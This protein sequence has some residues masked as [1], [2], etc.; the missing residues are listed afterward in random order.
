MA[1]VP[2][3]LATEEVPSPS[4]EKALW[5]VAQPPAA[6]VW[7]Q[8]S[9]PIRSRRP[10]H[11]WERFQ[12]IAEATGRPSKSPE[13]VSTARGAA[14]G[15]LP[16]LNQPGRAVFDHFCRGQPRL[17]HARFAE[18]CSPGPTEARYQGPDP[19]RG[20]R[21]PCQWHAHGCRLDVTAGVADEVGPDRPLFLRDYDGV[22]DSCHDKHDHHDQGRLGNPDHVER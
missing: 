16:A 10:N 2:N 3:S 5:H 22:H 8:R 21:T 6:I 19:G 13:S 12:E 7:N 1:E 17:L 9:T 20:L 4:L 15:S 18:R 11:V 14:G